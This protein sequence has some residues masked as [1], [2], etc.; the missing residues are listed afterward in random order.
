[1]LDN[2][3]IVDIWRLGTDNAS[4]NAKVIRHLPRS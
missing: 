3:D 2:R 4:V 1:M